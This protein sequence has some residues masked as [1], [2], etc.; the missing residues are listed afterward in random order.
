MKENKLKQQIN[1]PTHLWPHFW[2]SRGT[3]ECTAEDQSKYHTDHKSLN[4]ITDERGNFSSTLSK[5]EE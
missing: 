1:Q 2:G 3:P 5:G 4:I